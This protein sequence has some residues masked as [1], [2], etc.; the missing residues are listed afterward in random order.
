MRGILNIGTAAGG[1]VI[2]SEL[3]NV[4]TGKTNLRNM[5]LLAFF[6]AIIVVMAN[7]PFL[8]YIPLGFM[9]ATTIHIPVII[10]ACLLGPKAGAMLGGVFGLTSLINNTVKPIITSFVFT[11]FYSFDARFTGG[12]SSLIICFVPR[13]LIGVT[14]G[15]ACIWLKKHTKSF[16]AYTLSGFIGSFTN[17]FLVMGG[18]YL[19]FGQS[20]ASAKGMGFSELFYVI[21]GIVGINGVPEAIIASLLTAMICQ[22][23][24]KMMKNTYRVG[25]LKS[26]V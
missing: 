10:G 14:A 24:Q 17:T 15:Y 20:Y 23:L 8:G 13:I 3:S 11:P 2:M 16:V 5:V 6:A 19:L 9:N 1:Y 12:I 25:G 22:P 18:I 26:S 4:K 7:V 21:I